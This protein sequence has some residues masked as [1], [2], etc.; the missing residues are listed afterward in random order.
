MDK[1]IAYRSLGERVPC[2][3]VESLPGP[4]AGWGYTRDRSRALALTP[5]W[6]RQFADMCRRSRIIPVFVPVSKARKEAA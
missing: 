4:N 5:Y 3:F 6:Q 1:A 2:A